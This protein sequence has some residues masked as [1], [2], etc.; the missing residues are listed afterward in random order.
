LRWE[1][2]HSSREQRRVALPVYPFRKT[3]Y[4]FGPDP[5][6]KQQMERERIWQTAVVAAEVQSGQGPLGWD[7]GS[8]AE[9]WSTLHRLTLAHAQSVLAEAG[10]FRQQD[11]VSAD[12]VLQR[13]GF[14]PLYRRL[15]QHWLEGLAAN[16]VLVAE[17]D[18]FRA[19]ASFTAAP[20]ETC[21]R[22]TEQQLWDNPGMMAY[23]R[24]CSA[25]LGDVLTG[26][27][28]SLETL[29]PQGSF[30]IAE[31]LYETGPEAR[32]LNPIAAAAVNQVARGLGQRRNARV[33]E[34]GGGTGGTTS[35]I[36]P[37]LPAGQVEYWFTDVSEL[38][39]NRAQR[40]FASYPLVHYALFDLDRPLEEQ[41]IGAGQFDVIVAAN[42]VHASRNLKVA[43][44]RV[45]RLLA[46]GG[47]LVLM[48]WTT[49]HSCFDMTIGLIE[50]WQHFEDDIR[51]EHPLLH[52]EQWRSVLEASGFSSMV[53]LPE[54]AS[55]ASAIGEHVLI[56][57]SPEVD[58]IEPYVFSQNFVAEE[59]RSHES[60][61]AESIGE[62]DA[63]GRLR[64]LSPNDR[65]QAVLDL[66]RTTIQRVFNL[67]QRAEELTAR[68]R[69]SDLGMDSL[70][71]LE[72]RAELAKVFGLEAQISSTIA[73]DTG[74]VGE[75]AKA[76]LRAVEA[77]GHEEIES[78]ETELQNQDLPSVAQ[79][80]LD[81]LS[82]MSD[83][84]VERLLSERLS[85]R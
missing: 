36:L 56:A 42:V 49:H 60:M 77:S 85:R 11:P 24:Q 69:L 4:W 66:V 75:L 33:L 9:R 57:R 64:A 63:A 59:W 55:P 43:L 25:V 35:A 23:L 19:S 45:R 20:L 12:D 28:S 58:Q 8:Y 84:D 38:F 44:E 67:P 80:T 2:L 50:G 53:A 71:A 18:R 29:F 48:E 83:E 31:G 34:I 78:N 65:E 13:C 10:A 1:D 70:I 32:Y 68:E 16:G 52:T 39:L 37:T 17:G 76:L 5:K 41:G 26:R 22:E 82:E 30:S 14:Q 62:H 27:K 73:F 74:T 47:M 54:V 3:R 6:K 7:P 79:V 61:Q 15:V 46:P 72:L 51:Q 40:R 21:W 81:E